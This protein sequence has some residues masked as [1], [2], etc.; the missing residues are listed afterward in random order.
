MRVMLRLWRDYLGP[1][2]D[3]WDQPVQAAV[4]Y[5]LPGK[6]G[7]L[8]RFDG[9]KFYGDC[10]PWAGGGT[11]SKPSKANQMADGI[12]KL[13]YYEYPSPASPPAAGKSSSPASRQQADG[14][15]PVARSHG[16]VA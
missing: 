16:G 4:S 5:A 9:W 8:Y 15:S 3:Y 7:N 12:K 10:K 2:W 1:R 11:W 14:A 6:E 13:Y